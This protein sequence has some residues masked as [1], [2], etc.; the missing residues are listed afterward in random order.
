MEL[1]E[2]LVHNRQDTLDT[3]LYSLPLMCVCKYSIILGQ[4]FNT[5][6]NL[7]IAKPL[8]FHLLLLQQVFLLI[9][10]SSNRPS[11]PCMCIHFCYQTRSS[12][13]ILS[14]K[15][16][17][18]HAQHFN[19]MNF[20]L[21]IRKKKSLLGL[22]I[23]KLHS[24]SLDIFVINSWFSELLRI[25]RLLTCPQVQCSRD[26]ES[27]QNLSITPLSLNQLSSTVLKDQSLVF[28]MSKFN[29]DW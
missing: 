13:L 26:M 7:R 12:L 28:D 2:E 10:Y 20:K 8:D 16:K 4:L 14:C 6:F 17:T 22:G 11:I 15:I 18:L 3:M 24:C 27:Y 9:C 5:R 21:I 29:T 1:V 19:I 25:R 23:Q